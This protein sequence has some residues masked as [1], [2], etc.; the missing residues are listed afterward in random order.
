MTEKNITVYLQQQSDYRFEILFDGT[1]PVLISDE[2]A[3]L[4]TG[5]GPSPLQLLCAAVGNCLSD[6]LLFAFRKYKQSPEPIHCEVQAHVGRNE[7]GRVRVLMMNAK[8]KLGVA[9]SGLEH[10]DRVLSQFEEFCTVTQSV[11]QGIKIHTSV[12]DVHGDVLKN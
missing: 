5:T 6:S 7:Q 12:L 9:A 2:P 11:G 3:P 10:T 8:L 1:M 4:G